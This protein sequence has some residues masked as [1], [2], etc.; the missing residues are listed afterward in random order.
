VRRAEQFADWRGPHIELPYPGRW[1]HHRAAFL[2]A[3]VPVLRSL[4]AANTS[5]TPDA[6]RAVRTQRRKSATNR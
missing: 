5:L 2:R 4:G 1:Q 3:L 6:T